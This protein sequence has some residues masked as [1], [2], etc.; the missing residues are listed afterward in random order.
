MRMY[1]RPK[2]ERCCTEKCDARERTFFE[3]SLLR[4]GIWLAHKLNKLLEIHSK[5]Q[6]TAAAGTQHWGEEQEKGTQ[7]LTETPE[8]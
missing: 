3:G 7:R 1:E 8:D 6:V 4:R 5:T 2:R